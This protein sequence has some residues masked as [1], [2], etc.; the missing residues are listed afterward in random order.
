MSMWQKRMNAEKKKSMKEAKTKTKPLA[1]Y[2]DFL[3]IVRSE[4]N[5]Q[6]TKLT[7]PSEPEFKPWVA[8]NRV[9]G[10]IVYCNDGARDIT[11]DRQA[12]A[13]VTDTSLRWLFRKFQNWQWRQRGGA[14]QFKHLVV[15]PEGLEGEANEDV[16]TSTEQ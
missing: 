6:I 2:F 3:A 5:G 9:N 7:V 12:L 13:D 1:N 14:E 10:M 16:R 11:K 4:T 15:K 8:F